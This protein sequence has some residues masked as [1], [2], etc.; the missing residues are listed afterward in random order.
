MK[1]N[2]EAVG[3]DGNNIPLVMTVEHNDVLT[4]RVA[5]NFNRLVR[6]KELV[7]PSSYV[8]QGNE[9]RITRLSSKTFRAF[10]KDND[11]NKKIASTYYPTDRIVISEGIKEIADQIFGD[12]KVKEVVWPNTCKVIPEYCFSASDVESVQNI[13][14][15]KNVKEG[16]FYKN[17]S[18][19]SFVWPKKA[20]TIP[21][22]C[23]CECT[24]L[25]KISGIEDVTKIKN[26]AF[27]ASGIKEFHWPTKCCIISISCFENS[28]LESIDGV[29]DVTE[30]ED[31][32]FYA[33]RLKEFNWPKSCLTIPDR[34][35]SFAESLTEIRGIDNVRA[36][37]DSA[38]CSCGFK[39]FIWPEKCPVIPANCFAN[40]SN[41]SEVEFNGS[42][43][44]I[45]DG[46]FT[47]TRI[48]KLD[49]SESISCE[50]YDK[51]N[52]D[53]PEIIYPFYN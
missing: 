3:D 32:A 5:E 38:F 12:A 7:I 41:L 37:G 40:C 42:I 47:S 29:E 51:I 36:I 6:I 16:A 43:N 20:K 53:I 31:D 9:V 44:M 25:E 30:I 39:E 48:S 45:Q 18:L 22:E 15:V 2:I 11:D 17:H 10:I 8:S 21:K 34:C 35:F 26:F 27:G 19:T 50:V 28:Q 33:T 14:N 49:L 13:G 46:A 4:I 1:V 23:F 24:N 52:Q